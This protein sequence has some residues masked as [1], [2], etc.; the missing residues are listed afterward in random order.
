[1]CS[2]KLQSPTGIF[3]EICGT[4]H[5]HQTNKRMNKD[6]F[7]IAYKRRY[8]YKNMN[9]DIINLWEKYAL[10]ASSFD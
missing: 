1:M 7:I 5:S 4:G 6:M 8:V 10:G 9:K 3:K 2:N